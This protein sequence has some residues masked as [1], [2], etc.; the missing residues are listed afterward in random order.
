LPAVIATRH[1]AQV[2]EQAVAQL[3][4]QTVRSHALVAESR[5]ATSESFN[6]E[7]QTAEIQT[8]YRRNPDGLPGGEIQTVYRGPRSGFV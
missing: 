3:L 8:V 7:I 4:G 6:A 1:A 2:I 5:P